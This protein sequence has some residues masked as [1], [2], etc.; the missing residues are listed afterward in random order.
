MHWIDD[1]LCPFLFRG[2]AQV[3]SEANENARFL[4]TMR[5]CFDKFKE[6]PDFDLLSPHFRALFHTMMLVWKQSATYN[7]NL[8]LS[9]L[10]REL[11]NALIRKALDLINSEK[12]FESI[13]QNVQWEMLGRMNNSMKTIVDFKEMFEEYQGRLTDTPYAWTAPN[14][15]MFMRLDSFY[16]RLADMSDVLRIVTDFTKLEKINL[17]G[18]KGATLTAS[19]KQILDEFQEVRTFAPHPDFFLINS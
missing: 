5:P 18:T 15:V 9:C 4:N 10:M 8:R 7:N 13:D 2:S 3:R 14:K 19:L 6:V 17:G 16:E 1:F 11:C 12:Y